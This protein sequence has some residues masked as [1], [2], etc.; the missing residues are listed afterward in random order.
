MLFYEQC[1]SRGFNIW[2]GGAEILSEFSPQREMGG[3]GAA[4]IGE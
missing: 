1:C 3:I 2:A 4:G